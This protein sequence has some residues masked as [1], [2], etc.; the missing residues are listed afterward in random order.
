MRR[1][2]YCRH[3]PNWRSRE[4]TAAAIEFDSTV[5]SR[6]L[7]SQCATDGN[8][9][10]IGC[11]AIGLR[12]FEDEARRLGTCLLD[13]GYAATKEMGWLALNHLPGSID[14]QSHRS[15]TA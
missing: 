15:I 7:R 6:P 9:Q 3:R 12:D 5:V 4:T 2:G 1:S 14:T 13:T 11:P 10:T 8:L